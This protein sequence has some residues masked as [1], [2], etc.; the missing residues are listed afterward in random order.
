M[1]IKLSGNLSLVSLGPL[2]NIA[3]AI[4]LD[5]HFLDNLKEIYVLGGSDSGELM[6]KKTY[7]TSQY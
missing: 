6:S 2:T 7:L 5:P 4:K 3:L 1:G